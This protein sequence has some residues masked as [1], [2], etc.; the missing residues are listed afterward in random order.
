MVQQRTRIGTAMPVI[1]LPEVLI[2]LEDA[3]KGG[4]PERRVQMLRQITGLFVA[5]ADRLTAHQIDVFDDVF[6]RLIG[7]IEGRALSQLSRTLAGLASTPKQAIRRLALHEE[8]SVAA[9]VL[10]GSATVPEDDL[11]AISETRGQEHLLAISGRKHL[12][13]G[14]TDALLKHRDT[15]VCRLL[16]R[17]A[18][19]R[20][21]EHGY[22]ALVAAAERDDDV[23]DSLVL[24]RDL[25][26]K[27]LHALLAKSTKAV[28]ARLLKVAPQE[29]QDAVRTAIENIDAQAGS[30][31]P[32]PIDY[33]GAK[34]M[35]LALNKAGK[36]ND[37]AV[38]RFAVRGERL[39][40]IA[41]LSLLADAGI[42]IIE[43]IIEDVDPYGVM[44][45]CRA[46]RLNWDTTLAVIRHRH[47]AHAISPEEIAQRREAFEALQLSVAQRT[48][49]FGSVH[50]LAMETHPAGK[51]LA[52]AG[53]R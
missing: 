28:R 16:A 47:G 17:N 42:E 4:S 1:S 50:E 25:P 6:T 37:S 29:T 26:A 34:S 23:A 15:A 5:G 41:A 8:A 31:M 14:V 52:A 44:V 36:L 18:E 46:S 12:G 30:R 32:E 22:L 20:F 24:R 49:R 11:I 21:S 27:M 13:E 53:A 33:S 39:N 35:V 3:V 10:L 38:N 43:P 40:V 48:I 45:A 51:K 7:C 9:P 2:E 19:A